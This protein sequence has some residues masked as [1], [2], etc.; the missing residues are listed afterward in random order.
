MLSIIEYRF[1]PRGNRKQ[2]YSLSKKTN[3]QAKIETSA[4]TIP[5]PS[6]K[7]RRLDLVSKKNMPRPGKVIMLGQRKLRA[8]T[9]K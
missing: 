2:Q 1:L 6:K 4:Q 7:V 3:A 9:R 8:V 5:E